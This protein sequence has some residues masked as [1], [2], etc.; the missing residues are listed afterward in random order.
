MFDDSV[1][2]EARC[3][4]CTWHALWDQ[5]QM[6]A[7]LRVSG[8]LRREAKPDAALVQELLQG[9]GP[10]LRC[11]ECGEAGLLIG[12]PQEEEWNDAVLCEVCRKPIPGERLAALSGVKRCIECQESLEQGREPGEPEFCPKCGSLL[13]LKMS[14]GRGTTRYKMFCTGD[15][16]CRI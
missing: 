16:P 3:E 13:I 12:P 10:T 14:R 15:P 6:E 1:L 8:M 9:S 2:V 4:A 11:P 5:R 7:R